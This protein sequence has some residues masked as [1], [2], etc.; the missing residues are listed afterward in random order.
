MENLG[1]VG[2]T[3]LREN[4]IGNWISSVQGNSYETYK[5]TPM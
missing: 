1:D 2:E 4:E 5:K 3:R